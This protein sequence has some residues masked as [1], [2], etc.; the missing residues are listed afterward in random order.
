MVGIWGEKNSKRCLDSSG[1]QTWDHCRRQQ[2][3][4]TSVIRQCVFIKHILGRD[5]LEAGSIRNHVLHCY[6]YTHGKLSFFTQHMQHITKCWII[7]WQIIEWHWLEFHFVW[8]MSVFVLFPVIWWITTDFL[9]SQ[10]NTRATCLPGP[11]LNSVRMVITSLA[12]WRRGAA[13]MSL[14]KYTA[15]CVEEKVPSTEIS[16]N[17]CFTSKQ[18]ICSLH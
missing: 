3:L 10:N 6:S 4:W 16:S 15:S 18:F 14:P 2:E 13:N 9:S 7:S 1:S 8:K 11:R 5:V 12:D 17:V